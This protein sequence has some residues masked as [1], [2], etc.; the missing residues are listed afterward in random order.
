MTEFDKLICGFLI[1][2]FVTCV[3]FGWWQNSMAAFGFALALALT[4]LQTILVVVKVVKH[5]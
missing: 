2:A 5:D 3:L 4:V 1:N